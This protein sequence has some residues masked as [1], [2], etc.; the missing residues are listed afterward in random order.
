LF[1]KN[2]PTAAPD[3]SSRP[4]GDRLRVLAATA[5]AGQ[6]SMSSRTTGGAL[7]N[8]RSVAEPPKIAH[9]RGAGAES[10]R[11]GNSSRSGLPLGSVFGLHAETGSTSGP[12]VASASSI[13][14]PNTCRPE[15]RIGFWLDDLDTDAQPKLDR[16]RGSSTRRM[17]DR[18][19]LSPGRFRF[20]HTLVAAERP[21]P[22]LG[23]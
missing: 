18:T 2:P 16:G 21:R 4:S 9:L 20:D 12:C 17:Q 3:V 6:I 5:V 7:G 10:M 11:S 22:L 14:G 15:M 13:R 1:Q 23:W 19:P 8:S